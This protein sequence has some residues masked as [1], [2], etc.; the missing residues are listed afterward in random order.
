MTVHNAVRRQIVKSADAGEMRSIA[1]QN[2]MKGLFSNGVDL[3]K[4]GLT[5]ASEA[6]LAA[7]S[8]EED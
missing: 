5:T 4:K 6:I 7:R 8:Y 1:F 3:V 2:G